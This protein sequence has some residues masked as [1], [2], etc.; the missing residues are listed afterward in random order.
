MVQGCGL[1][2]GLGLGLKLRSFGH[3]VGIRMIANLCFVLYANELLWVR[4]MV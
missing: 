2:L 4:A 3:R 1:G